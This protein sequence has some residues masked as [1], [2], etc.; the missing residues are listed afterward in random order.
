MCLRNFFLL[1]AVSALLVAC[2]TEEAGMTNE[3]GRSQICFSAA[4]PLT[5]ASVSNTI[6]GFYVGAKHAD[7]SVFF[8]NEQAVASGGYWETSA[9]H[10]WPA[11]KLSF[12]AYA[13]TNTNDMVSASAVGTL[14]YTASSTDIANQPD[15]LVASYFECR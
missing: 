14:T 15:L 8:N 13:P 1:L 9:K 6:T 10:Y 3:K 11:G 7:G 2:S 4:E 5:K 12:Y